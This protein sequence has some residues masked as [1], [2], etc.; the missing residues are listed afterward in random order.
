MGLKA[1]DPIDD[2]ARLLRS[3]LERLTSEL[4]EVKRRLRELGS[5]RTMRA[6]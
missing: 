5:E 3:Y 2:E 4:V 6:S 1:T